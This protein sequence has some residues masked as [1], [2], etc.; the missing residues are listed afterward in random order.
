M[1]W[2][3]DFYADWKAKRAFENYAKSDQWLP[4]FAL[5]P[6]KIAHGDCRWLETVERRR[7]YYMNQAQTRVW[8]MEEEFR[9]RSN[10]KTEAV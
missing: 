9:P 8:L 10:G 2:N 7:R 1:K 6:V 3:C 5:I 4:H